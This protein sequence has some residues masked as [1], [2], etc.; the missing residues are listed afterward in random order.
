MN[1]DRYVREILENHALQVAGAIDPERFVLVDDNE[2]PNR[3]HT[4]N[5]FFEDHG[6]ERM[7]WPEKSPDMIRIEIVWDLFKRRISRRIRPEDTLQDLENSLVEEWNDLPQGYLD[8]CV[9]C[10]WEDALRR[11][12]NLWDLIPSTE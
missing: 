11:A 10:Q 9:C 4:V 2:H 5:N 3:V 6:L 7:D 8:K 1:S 12:S